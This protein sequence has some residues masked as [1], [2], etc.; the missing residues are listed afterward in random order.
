[1]NKRA[2]SGLYFRILFIAVLL[3]VV[4][5]VG[6]GA[7]LFT[8]QVIQYDKYSEK[9]KSQQTKDKTITPNRGGIYDTNMKPLAMSASTEMVTIEAIK[10]KTDEEAQLIAKN[11]SEILGLEYESVLK[12]AQSKTTYAVL[13]KGVEK[14]VADKVRAFVKE[15]SITSIF[16]V[17]DSTR[18][19]PFGNFASHV[20]GFVGSDQQGLDGIESLY[21]KY[22]KGIPGRLVTATNIK[23]EEMPFSYETYVDAVDG[24]DV[25]LTIDEVIQHY[26][27]QNIKVAYDDNGVEQ[28]VASIVMDV[29]T[30]GILAMASTPE[31]DPNQPFVIANKK[32]QA[33]LDTL[34]GDAKETEF[35]KELSAQ[36]RNKMVSDTYNPGSTFKIITAAMALEENV[37]PEGWT[38]NCTGSIMVPGWNK[39]IKCWKDGGHGVQTFE[40]AVENSCNPAFITIGRMV[41]VSNFSK[42]F[43]A[44]GLN[45]KTGIDVSGESK[46]IYYNESSMTEVDLAISSFGQGFQITPIQLLTAV[47]AVANDGYLMKPHL[48][49]EVRDKDGNVLESFEKEPLRQ[50]VSEETSKKVMKILEGVVS[51]G[52][53][54]NAYVPGYRV[55]GKTGTSEKKLLQA[56]T[57]EKKYIT[58]FV[59]VAPADD[60][61]IAVIVLLD[62]PTKYPISGGVQ[63]APVV[64]K[65]IEDTLPYLNVAPVYTEAELAVKDVNVPSVTEMTEAQAATALK[66]L[67]FK[68]K[69]VGTGE[70]VT[71][72]MPIAGSA[73]PPSVEIVL[74]MGEERPKDMVSVP[75]LTG[76]SYEKAKA[77]LKGINLYMSSGGIVSS[78]SLTVRKQSVAPGE[79]VVAGTVITVELSDKNQSAPT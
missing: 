50:V 58:S 64:R 8:L 24:N 57:G 5:F 28:Y 67:G 4:A 75:D 27:E 78:N 20:L 23:G 66:A 30:G 34:Q 54:K 73:V 59:A 38:F 1:M 39:P 43:K 70:K 16:L 25:V 15:N 62:E 14:D 26:V 2:D 42:Y 32:T 33:Y 17:P 36:W 61:K 46:G 55:G 21:E 10:I 40:Q 53:G 71:E 72:Q 7:R 6:I 56:Q 47:S 44:F 9:A 60:P 68:Y 3:G 22:M 69:K 12:K 49:K 31:Y 77:T 76:M 45:E 13:K 74:Y 48:V 37:V 19:Y 41:G 52:T 63:A 11:I 29:K 51:N 18:Y 79:K 35:K 65:I